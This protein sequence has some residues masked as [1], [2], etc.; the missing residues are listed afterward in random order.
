MVNIIRQIL[1][2]GLVVIF[3]F[4]INPVFGQSQ[5][6][7][8]NAPL[9]QVLREFTEITG[10][11]FLFRQAH[12]NEVTIS[13][14]STEN[15]AILELKR[16][17]ELLGFRVNLNHSTKQVLLVRLYQQIQSPE[18]EIRGN[19][20]DA[21]TREPLPYATVSWKV[22]NRLEGVYTNLAGEFSIKRR[23]RGSTLVLEARYVGYKTTS[24]QIDLR[25]V[26]PGSNLR[27]YLEDTT[28]R[29]QEIV[30][31]DHIGY[32]APDSLLSGMLDASRFSPLGESNTIRAL[33]SH[34]SVGNDGA[35]SDGIRVRGSPPDGFLVLLD[36]MTIFNQ[37]HLFGLIDSF[38]A[39]AIQSSGYYF[40]ITPAH[41]ES[42]TGG[43]LNLA[44]RTGSLAGTRITSSI[45]NTS[46]GFSMDGPING[47]SSWLI[48]AR[49]SYMDQI[50]WLGNDKL[51]EW[52][53]DVAR[54]R[55]MTS[56][57]QDNFDLILKPGTSSARFVDLH[58]KY[59]INF[60]TK[61][62]L[63]ISSYFG[64][65]Q[66]SHTAN[67]RY[68]SI[69]NEGDFD[70][71]AVT[72]K[73]E[74]GNGLVSAKYDLQL[75]NNWFSTTQAGFSA[76]KSSF[77]KDDMVYTQISGTIENQS[78]VVFIYPFKNTSIIQEAKVAQEIEYHSNSF[79]F[80]GGGGWRQYSGEYS[81]ATFDRIAYN[82]NQTADLFD[83]YTQIRFI[84]YRWIHLS[85]GMR[86]YYY[87]A[88]KKIR[89]S[90]RLHLK[91][92]PLPSLSL[93]SGYSINHQFLHKVALANTTTADVWIISDRNEPASTSEQWT[94]GLQWAWTPVWYMNIEYYRK[95]M[96]RIRV[97]EFDAPY[98][99]L[100]YEESPWFHQNEMKTN[101]LEVIVR[102]SFDWF[103]LTHTYSWSNAEIRNPFQYDGSYVPA[104]WHREHSYNAVLGFSP[105]KQTEVY[106]SWV[107]MTGT[108]DIHT[109]LSRS[110]PDRLGDY[111]R[112]DV[113]VKYNISSKRF[114]DL[115]IGLSVYNLLNTENVW[116][117]N[118][119][120]NFD[121]SRSIAR[122]RPVLV[123]VLDIGIQPSFIIRAKF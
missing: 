57:E 113:S 59:Q 69:N 45:S 23:F 72:S 55:K 121:E 66:T 103:K 75:S 62:R 36:G 111:Q 89:Y 61:G 17:L 25:S 32:F 6:E 21:K 118:Y 84:P 68:R 51:I 105:F 83:A 29:G 10:Y 35:I 42:P 5:I 76:Y 100:S 108:P 119:S 67:R 90:P 60:K 116:Y 74:W 91:L 78:S 117:R 1:F 7:Y 106:I 110:N 2:P 28:I 58:N 54:P 27:I 99:S 56:G 71:R 95:D 98:V 101:G 79:S 14:R 73:N 102:N 93:H 22:D 82:N 9:Q 20:Y 3:S 39:D 8:S 12:V 33:Q 46:I 53:L 104:P 114:N 15:D 19:I 70:F 26:N 24:I 4:W 63:S 96:S 40:G 120:F 122:L 115:E 109:D 86:A 43:T 80:I 94:L 50:R 88:D 16:Q 87:S 13:L 81:E 77:D 64:G 65:D 49:T 30:V 31:T 112:T 123:D 97:H 18:I 11:S 47:N 38:N 92:I 44:T 48:S 41:I 37:S 107:F 52:G 85:S 34:P